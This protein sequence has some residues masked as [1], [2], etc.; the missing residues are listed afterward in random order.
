MM[1][2]RLMVAGTV[3]VL[4]AVGRI[5]AVCPGGRFLRTRPRTAAGRVARVGTVRLP[6]MTAG[7]VP[8]RRR[9]CARQAARV[10]MGRFNP[11]RGRIARPA[12]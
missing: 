7:L 12:G 2:L 4:M 8:L 9:A 5:V 3:R 1:R 10:G 6:L 11:A